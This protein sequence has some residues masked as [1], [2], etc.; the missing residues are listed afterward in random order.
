[1][2]IWRSDALRALFHDTTRLAAA[3]LLM[4]AVSSFAIRRIILWE[5]NSH[6]IRRGKNT[7][8]KSM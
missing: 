6:N 5:N 3:P 7:G 8:T 1:M 2:Q 4:T